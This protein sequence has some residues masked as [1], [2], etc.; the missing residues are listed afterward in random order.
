MKNGV[1]S[2]RLDKNTAGIWWENW[3]SKPT[4]SVRFHVSFEASYEVQKVKLFPE[5]SG[6][7]LSGA[8]RLWFAAAA[9]EQCLGAQE[10]LSPWFLLVQGIHPGESP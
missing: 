2:A 1:N 4:Y 10:G 3:F 9:S 8:R 7:V 5:I 6:V